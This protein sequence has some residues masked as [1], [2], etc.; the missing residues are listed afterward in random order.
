MKYIEIGFGH[1]L[2]RRDPADCEPER[3]R[4]AKAHDA[5]KAVL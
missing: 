4:L 5:L 3:R 1:R 2:E